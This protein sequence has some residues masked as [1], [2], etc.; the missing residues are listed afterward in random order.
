MSEVISLVNSFRI[1]PRNSCLGKKVF[2]GLSQEFGVSDSVMIRLWIVKPKNSGNRIMFIL[3]R[4]ESDKEQ[5]DVDKEQD[6][7]TLRGDVCRDLRRFADGLGM[8][9]EEGVRELLDR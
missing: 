7:L 4:N 6:E 8:T 3:S 9:P 5:D 2:E 1:A